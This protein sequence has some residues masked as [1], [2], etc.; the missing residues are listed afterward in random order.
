[1]KDRIA[2]AVMPFQWLWRGC[3]DWEAATVAW[4]PRAA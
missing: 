2:F 3:F 4:R 1:M